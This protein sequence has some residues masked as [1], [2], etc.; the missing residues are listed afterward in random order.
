MK[1]YWV[2]NTEL[3]I[4]SCGWERAP[5]KMATVRIGRPEPSTVILD[6]LDFRCHQSVKWWNWCL[7]TLDWPYTFWKCLGKKMIFCQRELISETCFLQGK[8]LCYYLKQIL[9]LKTSTYSKSFGHSWFQITPSHIHKIQTFS[10]CLSF[11]Q[12]W[13]VDR[14]RFQDVT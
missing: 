12:R 9:K 7:A 10:K 5:A 13:L 2:I 1:Y 4:H 14:Y 3:L 11:F 6:G 8:K